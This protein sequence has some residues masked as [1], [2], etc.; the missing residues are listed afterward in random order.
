MSTDAETNLRW[1]PAKKASEDSAGGGMSADKAAAI[2]FEHE[3]ISSIALN[4]IKASVWNGRR[5]V[6]RDAENMNISCRELQ[7]T[8]P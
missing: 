4:G 8:G 6:Q 2:P 5:I 7:S 1:S 3:A